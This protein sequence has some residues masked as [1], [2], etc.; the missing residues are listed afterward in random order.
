MHK[1]KLWKTQLAMASVFL[2]LLPFKYGVLSLVGTPAVGHVVQLSTSCVDGKPARPQPRATVEFLVDGAKQLV[3]GGGGDGISKFCSV[4]LG[5]AVGV[6]YL[7]LS[8][9]DGTVAT[10]GNPVPTFWTFLGAGIFLNI[11]G[12][13]VL[14]LT[15]R[16]PAKRPSRQ[17]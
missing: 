10:V 11:I 1:S 3:L 15:R 12:N 6:T 13:L 9:V 2:V 7:H 8:W 14:M 16:E 5:N 4:H 17:D